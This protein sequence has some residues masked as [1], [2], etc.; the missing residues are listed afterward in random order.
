MMFTRKIGVGVKTSWQEWIWVLIW[1]GVTLLVLSLP[2]L[3]GAWLSTPANQFGGFVIGVEDGNAYLAKMRIGAMGDWKFHLFYTSEPHDGVYLFLF[4]LILGKL[5][6]LSDLSLVLVYHAA[7][8]VFGFG[9][10]FTLYYFA[11]FFT[12]LVAV[13]RLVFGL[14]A[15]GSGLG[16]LVVLLGWVD[17]LEL[18][19]DFYLP[20][21]FAF[22]LL[23]AL[24]HLLLAQTLLLWAILFLVVSWEKTSWPAALIAGAVLLGVAVIAVFYVLIAAVVMGAGLIL[25]QWQAW[26]LSKNTPVEKPKKQSLPANI[27]WTPIGL[28]LVAFLIPLP[29]LLYNAYIFFTNPVLKT[30]RAE[31]IFLSPS[32]VHYLLAVGILVLL[33]LMGS[34]HEWRYGSPRSLILIGWGVTALV[35]LYMP[36]SFQRRLM[37]GLQVPLSILAAMGLWVRLKRWKPFYWRIVSIGLVVFLSLSN[38][39]I[40]LGSFIEI[41]RQSSPVFHRAS[42]I[43]A[44]DWLGRSALPDDVVLAGYQNGNYLPSRMPA[45]VFVGHV[46]ETNHSQAKQL[47]LPE[48]FQQQNEAFRRQL[49]AE[50]GITYLFYGPDERALGDFDPA[51]APYLEQVYRNQDIQIYRTTIDQ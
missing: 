31:N 47:L 6:R 15:W 36:F 29:V 35:L 30:W 16:W 39:M 17:Q 21:A 32:P 19:L 46:T 12:P 42:Q 7:R 5:A 49:L 28:T 34:I 4:H 23:Y 41:N 37:F 26:W 14:V 50:Y 18:P 38:L 27:K 24:P 11:A 10:L 43:D 3:Y 20:E 13:R 51:Q 48:F 22:H 9:L 45:R 1:S 8:I 40:L 33:A 2:Y 25:Y 44:A